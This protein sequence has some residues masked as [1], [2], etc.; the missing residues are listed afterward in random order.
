MVARALLSF[1]DSGGSKAYSGQEWIQSLQK[2]VESGFGPEI[3]KEA[4]ELNSKI[5]SLPVS[6]FTTSLSVSVTMDNSGQKA[7]NVAFQWSPANCG[8]VTDLLEEAGQF[9]SKLKPRMIQYITQ[10]VA[11]L[12]KETAPKPLIGGADITFPT[13]LDLTST[14]PTGTGI[15]SKQNM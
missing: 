7:T 11:G 5:A 14:V 15:V 8:V 10:N 13:A 3:L 1:L 2:I 4:T 9:T 6:I 12:P